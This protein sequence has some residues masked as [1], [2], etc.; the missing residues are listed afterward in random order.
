MPASPFS[1]QQQ[2]D[3]GDTVLV[4]AGDINRAAEQEMRGA[5]EAAK[6]TPGRLILNFD[7]VSYVN[8]TGIA[9]IV[10]VLTDARSAGREVVAVGLTPHYL[11]IFSITR[12]SDFITIYP[13]MASARTAN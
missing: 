8:S 6:S 4:L 1:S 10:A 11:E 5:Y 12:L 7:Q 13:D 2:D 9:L 3:N